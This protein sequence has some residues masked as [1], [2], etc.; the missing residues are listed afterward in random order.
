MLDTYNQTLR[1]LI[2]LRGHWL[3]SVPEIIP[4]ALATW[5]I[6]SVAKAMI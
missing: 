6:V 3:A 5:F 2:A 4:A 1:S